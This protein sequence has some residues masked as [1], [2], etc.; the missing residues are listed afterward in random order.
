MNPRVMLMV[1]DLGVVVAE[2]FQ[3][4]YQVGEVQAIRGTEVCLLHKISPTQEKKVLWQEDQ[5]RH[6]C[7]VF[8]ER[9]CWRRV[10]AFPHLSISSQGRVRNERTGNILKMGFKEN[11][12]IVQLSMYL[13]GS[14]RTTT[15]YVNRLLW[16]AFYGEIP[17][18]C[19]VVRKDKERLMP[20]LGNLVVVRNPG[21][22]LVEEV[23]FA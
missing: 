18:G 16:E 23:S 15:R 13:N 1:G 4:S 3:L 6:I 2:G 7:E 5:L 10:E 21:G 22:R 17:V 14:K 9:E 19:S 20:S 12:P 8:P 11:R